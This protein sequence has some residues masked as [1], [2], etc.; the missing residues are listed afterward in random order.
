M[1]VYL[2]FWAITVAFSF[3]QTHHLGLCYWR[4]SLYSVHA[5]VVC[6]LCAL[7][8]PSLFK[9]LANLVNKSCGGWDSQAVSMNHELWQ[10]T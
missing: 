7:S 4:L 1:T 5:R 9:C 6:C 3:L 10:Y 8:S 2:N